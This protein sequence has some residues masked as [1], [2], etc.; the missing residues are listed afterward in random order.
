[1]RGGRHEEFITRSTRNT[2]TSTYTSVGGRVFRLLQSFT[3]RAYHSTLI[4]GA[5]VNPSLCRVTNHRTPL[6]CIPA[7]SVFIHSPPSPSPPPRVNLFRLKTKKK[8]IIDFNGGRFSYL[9]C[10]AAQGEKKGITKRFLFSYTFDTRGSVWKNNSIFGGGR[11]NHLIA[12]RSK[13]LFTHSKPT[14]RTVCV[15]RRLKR[16][17]FVFYRF[18]RNGKCVLQNEIMLLKKKTTNRNRRIERERENTIYAARL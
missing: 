7:H 11:G 9:T 10:C 16:F 1:M 18:G 4:G 3:R 2:R 5:R 13:F 15:G 8:I 12:K 6:V 17:F 14:L